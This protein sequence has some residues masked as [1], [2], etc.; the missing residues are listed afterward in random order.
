MI[1][2][3]ANSW[4]YSP[5]HSHIW[6]QLLT[7][8][9]RI[10]RL[11]A[12]NSAHDAFNRVMEVAEKQGKAIYD[13]IVQ[14]HQERL[15]RERD[16]GAYAFAA[17]RIALERIELPQIRDHRLTILD[18]EDREWRAQLERKAQIIPEM[19]PLLLIRLDGGCAND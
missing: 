8:S 15:T 13:E 3:D 10:H 11:L 17:R 16:K 2:I 19:A 18:R 5:D 9:P 4:Y 14:I 6:N 12:G 1:K 7:V